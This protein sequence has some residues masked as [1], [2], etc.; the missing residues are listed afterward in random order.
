MVSDVLRKRWRRWAAL[1]EDPA[2]LRDAACC[3]LVLFS[4]VVLVCVAAAADAVLGL[5]IW[6][7]GS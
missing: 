4:P 6:A 1:D 5:G 7:E 3:L 2:G